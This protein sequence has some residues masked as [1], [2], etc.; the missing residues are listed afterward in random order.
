[1]IPS[2]SF[3]NPK[4]RERKF[5]REWIADR[6]FRKAFLRALELLKKRKKIT[7]KQYVQLKFAAY[8]GLPIAGVDGGE[9]T[10]AFITHLRRECESKIAGQDDRPLFDKLSDWWNELDLRSLVNQATNWIVDNWD[11]V[12]KVALMLLAFLAAAK[13]EEEAEAK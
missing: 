6:R 5:D 8:N 11:T 3:A 12:L 13:A 2:V 1:M 4:K 10:D 9:R 7:P